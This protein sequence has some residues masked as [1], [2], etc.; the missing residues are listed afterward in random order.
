MICMVAGTFLYIHTETNK[1]K[2][3]GGVGGVGMWVG[4]GC[5]VGVWGEGGDVR[6]GCG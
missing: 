5:E 2:S 6:W 1:Q 4:W 3:G